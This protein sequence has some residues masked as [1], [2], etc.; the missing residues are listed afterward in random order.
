MSFESEKKS[1]VV[2]LL[3]HDLPNFPLG[4][5][6]IK[7]CISFIIN[8]IVEISCIITLRR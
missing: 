8:T 6:Q 2:K 5:V 7:H 1:F 4:S 3:F